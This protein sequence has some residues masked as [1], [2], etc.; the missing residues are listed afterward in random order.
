MCRCE[1]GLSV[2]KSTATL[3]NVQLLAVRADGLFLQ[4]RHHPREL[5]ELGLVIGLARNPEADSL[6]MSLPA[7]DPADRRWCGWW[8]EIRWFTA[9]VQVVVAR[10]ETS[11]D[12]L[13]G[14]ENTLSI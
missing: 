14:N 12:Q 13:Y 8:L 3:V 4:D 10:P 2:N 7:S 1:N 5:A 6:G 11:E 9:N